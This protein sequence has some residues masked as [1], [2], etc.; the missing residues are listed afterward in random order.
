MLIDHVTQ[1]ANALL[2]EDEDLVSRLVAGRKRF[3]NWLQLEI[4]KRLIRGNGELEIDLEK[5]YPNLQERCDLWCREDAQRESWVELKICV[6]NYAQNFTG[7]S[8]PRPITNQISDIIRDSEKLQRIQGEKANRHI[9]LL[10]YPMPFEYAS[11]SAWT[12]HLNR[13]RASSCEIFEAFSLAVER[14]G[15]TASL[16]AYKIAI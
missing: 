11:N 16:V 5:P 7:P 14:S 13:I 3:E 1:H 10:T 2:H 6:T 9:L 8:S 4:F 12:S 15:R